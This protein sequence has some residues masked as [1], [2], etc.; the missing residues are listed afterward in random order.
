MAAELQR[1]GP[2][3][4]PRLKSN[5]TRRRQQVSMPL[6]IVVAAL[7]RRVIVYYRM[8]Q[9][10][11]NDSTPTN[12]ASRRGTDAGSPNPS[13]GFEPPPLSDHGAT[14]ATVNVTMSD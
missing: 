12:S 6:V 8:K 3:T 13:R 14:T 10:V 1:S 2:P 7:R 11:D 4:P 5:R 9:F